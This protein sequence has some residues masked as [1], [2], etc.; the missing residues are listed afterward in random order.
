MARPSE[1]VACSSSP[2]RRTVSADWASS[3]A[4]CRVRSGQERRRAGTDRSED[5]EGAHH[6]HR[7]PEP[8]TFLVGTP[9]PRRTDQGHQRNDGDDGGK[10]EEPERRSPQQRL[11][12]E[13]AGQRSQLREGAAVPGTEH[14]EAESSQPAQ[15]PQPSASHPHHGGDRS[16]PGQRE[17]S[18]A[19]GRPG[20][21]DGSEAAPDGVSG[22]MPRRRSVA[23]CGGDPGQHG[24]DGDRTRRPRG[25]PLRRSP[26]G[27]AVRAVIHEGSSLGGGRCRAT[28]TGG[29]DPGG[30]HR[31]S[32][33]VGRQP[34]RRGRGGGRP[35]R[36]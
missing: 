1:S 15:A 34:S 30:P 28:L 32:G 16:H 14:G 20:H 3:P 17:R 29:R 2:S 8:T 33:R 26:S 23:Q 24:D 5:H 21:H 31:S 6:R 4:V 7:H 11:D 22:A 13:G 25:A 27:S 12:G 9:S 36:R 19:A 10:A 35:R 18:G